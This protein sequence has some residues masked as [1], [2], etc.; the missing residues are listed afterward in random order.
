MKKQNKQTEVKQEVK[1]IKV[2]DIVKTSIQLG[3]DNLEVVCKVVEDV[4]NDCWHV[5]VL[6]KPYASFL[7][8]TKD[9]EVLKES[10]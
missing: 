8:E 10:N 7:V 1:S 6:D 2:N 5:K 4:G 9:V 3:G